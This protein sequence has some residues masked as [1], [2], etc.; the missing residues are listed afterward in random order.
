MINRKNI[1]FAIIVFAIIPACF[2]LLYAQTADPLPSWNDNETK[3]RIISFVKKVT[4][5]NSGSFVP[6]HE[7]IAVFD[8]DGTLW[9]EKPAYFQQAFLLHRID[10]ISD[11]YPEWKM[12][13]PFKAAL[14]RDYDY[15]RKMDKKLLNKLF[16]MT[17][18]K[19][20]QDEFDKLAHEF[21]NTAKHPKLKKLY[22][23]LVYQPMLELMDYLR[24]NGFKVFICSGGGLEFIRAFSYAVYGVPKENVIGTTFQYEMK[25]DDKGVYIYRKPEFVKPIN[26]KS[27][28]AVM[29]QRYIGTRPIF[30][31]GNSNGDIQM[32]RFVASGDKPSMNLLL[33]HDD[34]KREFKY[35]RGAKVAFEIAQ[36]NNWQVVSIKKDFRVVFPDKP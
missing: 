33:M 35:D 5:A 26:L 29:I 23:E 20:S 18:T 31:V 30:G 2:S 13:Q 14:E 27:G 24:D 21:I 22:K 4:D 6:K 25:E 10:Q 15:L 17:H 11:K 9:A 32:L 12:K 1:A 19:M 28:K 16:I 7:R 3:K 34:E 8:N 36:K